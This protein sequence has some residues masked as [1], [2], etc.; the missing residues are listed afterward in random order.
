MLLDN[1]VDSV[2]DLYT[3]RNVKGERSIYPLNFE[4]HK[5]SQYAPSPENPPNKTA[6]T[7]TLSPIRWKIEG[8]PSPPPHDDWPAKKPKTVQYLLSGPY[9]VAHA[10]SPCLDKPDDLPTHTLHRG[11]RNRQISFGND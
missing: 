2:Q 10:R 4:V 8:L 9:K 7:K 5:P 3:P 6:T 11:L 1:R